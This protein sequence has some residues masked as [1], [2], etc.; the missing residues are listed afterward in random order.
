ME[1]ALTEQ[2]LGMIVSFLEDNP[3]EVHNDPHE[4]ADIL[5]HAAA[6]D[7]RFRR[8]LM[9]WLNRKTFFTDIVVNGYSLNDIA[10]VYCSKRL[11]ILI[12][13]RLLWDESEGMTDICLCAG[14]SCIAEKSVLAGT[15][16]ELAILET[17]GWYLYARDPFRQPEVLDNMGA[18]TLYRICEAHPELIGLLTA[19]DIPAGSYAERTGDSFIVRI[20]AEEGGI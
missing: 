5:A 3:P 10:S 2:Q 6:A 4:F 9:E 18:Y 13:L 14:Q 20:N 15:P 19:D 16:V 12:A 8:V 17:N 11:G 7:P 1:K